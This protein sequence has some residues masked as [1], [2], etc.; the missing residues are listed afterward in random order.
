MLRTARWAI[1][2]VVA[3]MTAVV[4][5]GRAEESTP[6]AE[7][8]GATVIRTLPGIVVDRQAKEVRLAGKIVQQSVGL[9][10]FACGKNTRE[11]EAVIVLEA[12][13][14]HLTFALA[15]LGL[16][17]GRPGF[18]TEGGAF[19]P[20]AGEALDLT[21]RFTV[22]KGEGDQ[23]K[24]EVVTLPAWRL[25]RPAGT[26]VGLTRPIEWVY[27]GRPEQEALRAADRE[28]TAIGLSNFRDVVIDVPFESTDAN[29]DLLYQANPE[30][31]PPVGT[32]VEII[33]RP[34]GRQIAPQKVEVQVILAKGKQPV[35]DGKPVDLE[36]LRETVN[37]LP[38]K[39]R[40]AV[41]KADADESFGRVMEV[42]DVLRDAMLNVHLVAVQA[43]E[44]A[45]PA[46]PAAPPTAVT[47]TADDQVRV[48]DK[49]VSLDVFRRQAG[50]MLKGVDR[51][52]LSAEAKGSWK[53]VAEVLEI[54][55]QCGIVA[56]VVQQG[57][58]APKE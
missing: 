51:V 13:P 22:E 42:R 43:A 20:A 27:V 45:P 47:V 4:A 46:P 48:G 41:L 12:R 23:K 36:T 14:S 37:A 33:I 35:L 19:S 28:G 44:A 15:L 7:G 3:G 21:V 1:L 11:H 34:T 5:V 8:E 6:A 54:T 52:T 9:E 56:T 39:V 18:I 25:L 30:V 2:A 32:P 29:A 40:T 49:T 26:E 24:E 58:E 17:P 10:L 31:V 57:A 50:E 53:T 55:R 16:E 38:A